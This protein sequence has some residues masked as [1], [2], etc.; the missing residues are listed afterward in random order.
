MKNLYVKNNFIFGLAFII[1]LFP[2]LA[3]AQDITTFQ[4]LPYVDGNVSDTSTYIE[5]LYRFS[6][7]VAAFLV[8]FKIIIAGARLTISDSVSGRGKAKEDILGALLGMLIILGAVTLLNTI[9]PNLTNLNFLGEADPIVINNSSLPISSEVMSAEKKKVIDQGLSLDS[10]FKGTFGSAEHQA[11]INNCSDIGGTS[12]GDAAKN[13]AA[14][15][16]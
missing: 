16:K 4:T 3:W 9:N 1:I 13:T 14:C 6:I 12:I 10:V 8:V 2:T 7:A 11:F 15:Y 5:L